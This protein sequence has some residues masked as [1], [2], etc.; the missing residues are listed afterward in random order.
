MGWFKRGSSPKEFKKPNVQDLK[1][2]G[3][4]ADPPK[5]GEDQTPTK[6]N[7]NDTD[8]M[9][10]NFRQVHR[11]TEEAVN[12][13]MPVLDYNGYKL[14]SLH[15]PQQKL[16]GKHARALSKT[17]EGL[18]RDV[19]SPEYQKAIREVMTRRPVD[20]KSLGDLVLSV[21]GFGNAM[22]GLPA[23]FE[24][25]RKSGLYVICHSNTTNPAMNTPRIVK[26]LRGVPVPKE[27]QGKILEIGS[28]EPGLANVLE[29]A[30]TLLAQLEVLRS[31]KAFGEY[32]KKMTGKKLDLVEG[33]THVTLTGHSAGGVS[34]GMVRKRLVEELGLDSAI[35]EVITTGAPHDGAQAMDGLTGLASAWN[36]GVSK[37]LGGEAMDAAGWLRPSK[38]ENYWTPADA[39]RYVDLAIVGVASPNGEHVHPDFRNFMRYFSWMGDRRPGD[40]LIDAESASHGRR[41]HV[42]FEDHLSVNS[43]A[44]VSRQMLEVRNG[45]LD[46]VELNEI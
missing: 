21:P 2:K 20:G 34:A 3:N 42:V 16:D 27:L 31:H 33:D 10:T 7:G 1:V 5:K 26:E 12:G 23:I 19:Q 18:L 11:V 40:G 35:S 4:R 24:E 17:Q 30:D 6:Y 14:E 9:K 43:K 44:S 13:P 29:G 39:A 8:A 37:Q 41:H 32:F 15:H 22:K 38:L 45:L 25:A 46:P 36:L 28:R